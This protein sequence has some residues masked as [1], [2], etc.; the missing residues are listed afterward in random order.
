MSSYTLG[1]WEVSLHQ[2]PVWAVRSSISWGEEVL[3][4]A[5]LSSENLEVK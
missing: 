2:P 1:N 4:G 3:H 5:I